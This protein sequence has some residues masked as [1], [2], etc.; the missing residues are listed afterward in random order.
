MQADM[1]NSEVVTINSGEG[2]A[3]G[4]AILAGVGAGIYN[5]VAE[6]CDAVIKKV[7]SQKPIEANVKVYNS[8]YPIYKN[9]YT[10][11][12]PQFKELSKI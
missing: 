2:P 3:L 8:Y 5:S 4:V 11:L 6:G 1:F 9:I 12:K 10:S 7:T